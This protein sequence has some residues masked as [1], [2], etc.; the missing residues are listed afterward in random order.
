MAT[1]K[2]KKAK[3][4]SSDVLM[5]AVESQRLS[6]GL[7]IIKFLNFPASPL[8]MESTLARNYPGIYLFFKPKPS[9]ISED[10]II[11]SIPMLDINA[12]YEIGKI[13]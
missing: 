9:D 7:I 13:P 3:G 11:P 6:S 8:I 1:R 5:L 12:P 2:I 10:I 4:L